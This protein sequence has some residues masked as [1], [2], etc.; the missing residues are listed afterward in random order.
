MGPRLAVEA[1][2]ADAR[3][4]H[5][6]AHEGRDGPPT[7]CTHELRRSP[8]G[9]GP[10]PKLLP[11]AR[12]AASPHPFTKIGYMTGEHEAEGHER[13]EAPALGHGARGDRRR[14]VH[15]DH[16]KRNSAPRAPCRRRRQEE[17]V[18]A[19][20]ARSRGPATVT[21]TRGRASRRWRRS[22]AAHA[23]HLEREAHDPEPEHAD[24]VHEEVH[25]HRV[26]DVLR[27][28][29]PRLDERRSPRMNIT[30][31]PVTSVQTM[32]SAVCPRSRA[33]WSRPLFWPARL[34]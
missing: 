1:V 25:P 18:R 12:A 15:E 6:R 29:Q 24:R 30:R 3:A 13:R 5:F 26:R 32:L 21:T 23:A 28:R 16:L 9:R 27:A 20:E 4:E 31:K 7:M 33:A 19:E 10:R 11:A 34:R 14:G 2:L 17:P 8:R 22:T